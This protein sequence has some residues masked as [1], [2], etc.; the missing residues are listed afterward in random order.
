[1]IVLSPYRMT[2]REG[3]VRGERERARVRKRERDG[4][5][6]GG[7]QRERERE[8]EREFIGN[9]SLMTN[10]ISRSRYVVCH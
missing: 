3:T 7:R 8:S 6:E 1:M 10:T 5:T 9:Y 4:R 2:E